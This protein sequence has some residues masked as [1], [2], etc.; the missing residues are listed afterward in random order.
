VKIRRL[1]LTTGA[2]LAL[3]APA[4][5]ASIDATT[6]LRPLNPIA[7][8]YQVEVENTS[9]I[10]FINTFNWVPPSQLTIIAIT[11]TKGGTCHLA[12]NLIMCSGGK[13]G[14]APPT[15]SCHAGGRLTVNFTATGYSPTFNGHWWT[16]W[17]IG[18]STN[19]TSMTPVPYH[20]PSYLQTEDLPI[21]PLGTQPSDVDPSCQVE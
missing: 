11:S 7:G 9:D 5:Y 6:I 18:S 1:I 21:C 2:I 15:C 4:A 10:G 14:I 16:Y 20:I 19:I 13:Q 17:G 12:N 3:A 8:K